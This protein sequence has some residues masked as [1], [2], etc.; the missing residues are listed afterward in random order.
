MSCPI[1]AFTIFSIKVWKIT[2]SEFV[3]TQYF[4]KIRQNSKKYPV[5][6]ESLFIFSK[7]LGESHQEAIVHYALGDRHVSN[8]RT[9][10]AN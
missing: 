8:E 3:F 2:P 10:A 1:C 6:F 5:Q 7:I 9:K 4:V